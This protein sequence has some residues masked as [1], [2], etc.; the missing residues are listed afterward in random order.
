MQD[1]PAVGRRR[2]PT[3][4]RQPGDSPVVAASDLRSDLVAR[5][6][7][8]DR[9]RS[10]T[11][12]WGQGMTSAG[13]AVTITPGGPGVP[14]TGTISGSHIYGDQGVYPVTISVADDG[15]GVGQGSFNATV[16]DV[17]PTLAPLASMLYL[18]GQPVNVHETFTEPGIADVDTVL[19]NWGD[20]DISN[21]DGNS[22]YTNASGDL[23]PFITEP[24]ASNP[25][26]STSS[27]TLKPQRPRRRSPAP[28]RSRSPTRMASRIPFPPSTRPPHLE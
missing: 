9:E 14:T 8:I 24:T 19:V 1:I 18:D 23:V 2:V 20:G 26:G 15:G 17:G 13:R 12:D 3:S 21:F 22:M 4:D 7:L 11:I 28:P 25:V 16:K 10:A 27:S 6:A 5:L